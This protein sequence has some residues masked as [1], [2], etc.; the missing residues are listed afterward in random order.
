MK[1][2]KWEISQDS[3]ETTTHNTTKTQFGDGYEQVVSHGINNSR[4][5]W[6]CS[7]TDKKAVIDE[8]YDFLDATKSVEVF[9][10]QPLADEPRIKVRLDGEIG[11]R[12]LGGDVW[13]I[14]FNL[15]QTF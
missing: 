6:Q 9:T 8:I 1:H 11:R 15:K 10:F 13:Q 7:K 5:L 12:Q 14:N 3:T 2:F 4:K